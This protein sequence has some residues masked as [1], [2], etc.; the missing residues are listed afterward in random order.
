M[1]ELSREQ[2]EARIALLD[3]DAIMLDNPFTRA[4]LLA[5]YRMALT[6]L[7]DDV[8]V[9]REGGPLKL[10][11]DRQVF[12]YEQDHYYLSNFSSFKVNWL[13]RIF[14]TSEHAYHWT[15]FP[16]DSPERI[17]IFNAASAHDAFRFAQEHKQY[18]RPEWP[19]IKVKVMGQ[20]L[21]AKVRQHEYVS[22]KLLQTGNRELIEN[23]WRDDF[24]GWGE[25]RDGQNML[26]KLWM[27]IRAELLAASEREAG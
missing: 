2:I 6:A 26:G 22:R 23:S 9:P 20:I 5:V 21:R 11:N 15:R 7:S 12:F 19:D 4:E 8:R 24:W 3:G 10:D 1:A 14:P 27:E 16:E 18:Q 17:V 13:G 25:N